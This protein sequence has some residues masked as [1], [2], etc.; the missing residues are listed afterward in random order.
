MTFVGGIVKSLVQEV[1]EEPY[2]VGVLEAVEM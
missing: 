2:F 1:K